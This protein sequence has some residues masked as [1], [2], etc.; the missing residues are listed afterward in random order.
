MAWP[1]RRLARI[2]TY[3]IAEDEVNTLKATPRAAKGLVLLGRH[4]DFDAETFSC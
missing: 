1:L 3:R 4:N 2:E